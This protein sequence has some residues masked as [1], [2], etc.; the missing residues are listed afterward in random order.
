MNRKQIYSPVHKINKD[1]EPDKDSTAAHCFKR[2]RVMINS[3][4]IVRK[5]VERKQ[6]TE[7]TLTFGK[8]RIQDG[9]GTKQLGTEAAHNLPRDILIN[10][11][12]M[13]EY[14]EDTECNFHARLKNQIYL[15]S[16]ATVIV[17][18]GANYIDSQWERHGLLDIFAKY[19]HKCIVIKTDSENE[20][21][22]LS[23]AGKQ[24]TVECQETLSNTK[25]IIKERKTYQCRAEKLDKIFETYN[26]TI[27][28]FD[29]SYFIN[30]ILG[31]YRLPQYR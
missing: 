31:I 28:E 21:E 1:K 3:G 11:R 13:W 19:L 7:I 10:N 29:Y 30:S 2:L 18:K 9:R 16:A 12:S 27:K 22:L 5:I 15:T 24:L 20:F 14:L 26:I 4:F 25:M 23:E 6:L 17:E 8:A